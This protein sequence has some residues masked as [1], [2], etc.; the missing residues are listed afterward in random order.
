MLK[1]YFSEVLKSIPLRSM[2]EVIKK[3]TFQK[4]DRSTKKVY[5][6]EARKKY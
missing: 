2:K 3:Y 5:F 1:V 6:S 4:H